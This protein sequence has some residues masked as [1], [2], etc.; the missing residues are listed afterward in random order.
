MKRLRR[1]DMRLRQVARLGVSQQLQWVNRNITR[2]WRGLVE[3]NTVAPTPVQTTDT[4]GL[5]AAAVLTHAAGANVLLSQDQ[6]A[7]AYIPGRYDGTIDLVWAEGSEN[8][9][10]VDPTHGWWR[11]ARK[12]RTHQIVAHHIGLITNDLPK[13]AETL[14]AILDDAP[15]T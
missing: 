12:V 13:L 9:Q 10:R 7:S 1:Y 11:V 5:D 4:T 6:A 8:V 14:R 15:S 2:R 3:P